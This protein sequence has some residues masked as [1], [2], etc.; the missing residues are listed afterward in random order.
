MH[1]RCQMRT[2][3]IINLSFLVRNAWHVRWSAKSHADRRRFQSSY[4]RGN[5]CTRLYTRW[6][7]DAVV[8]PNENA[9][10][11]RYSVG[12]AWKL[13]YPSETNSKG[14]QKLLRLWL[15]VSQPPGSASNPP[16]NTTGIFISVGC[17]YRLVHSAP[18]KTRERESG[19]PRKRPIRRIKRRI[20]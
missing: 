17:S 10:N 16:V 12:F 13:V 4:R 1:A 6:Y 18:M 11:V 5:F 3:R 7:I 9:E 20:R 15:I 19:K 8:I 2:F 14:K